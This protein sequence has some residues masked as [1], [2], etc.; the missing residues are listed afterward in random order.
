MSQRRMVPGGNEIK[1][2]WDCSP[3]NIGRGE[4]KPVSP[5]TAWLR[6]SSRSHVVPAPRGLCLTARGDSFG[7]LETTHLTP[8][9]IHRQSILVR[10]TSSLLGRVA[11][12]NNGRWN[13]ER[14]KEDRG[15]PVIIH[16][17]G[18]PVH[19]HRSRNHHRHSTSSH[20]GRSFLFDELLP[21]L[22]SVVGGVLVFS[23]HVAVGLMNFILA[24]ALL[25]FTSLT[26]SRR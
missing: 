16:R 13:M 17:C 21:G 15:R 19:S 1:D 6:H 22:F 2:E 24:A 10:G 8:A 18:G 26:S 7:I 3:W 25:G 4:G 12:G 20:S 5:G 11:L 14:H 23:A 9:S